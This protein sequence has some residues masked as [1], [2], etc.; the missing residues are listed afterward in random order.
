[1]TTEF[2]IEKAL[3]IQSEQVLEWGKVLNEKAYLML[4]LGV[5]RRNARG[6]KSASEV[7]RGVDIESYIHNEIMTKL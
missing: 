7:F 3:A 2:T 5:M 1:M 6:Y 4:C